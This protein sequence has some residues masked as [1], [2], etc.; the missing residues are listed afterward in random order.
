MNND[1]GFGRYGRYGDLKV[2]VIQLQFVKM[3]QV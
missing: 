2:L 3:V 1:N